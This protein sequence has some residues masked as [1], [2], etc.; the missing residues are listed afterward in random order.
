MNCNLMDSLYTTS[1]LEQQQHFMM[2][3]SQISAQLD[4]MNAATS[5]GNSS[6]LVA[7]SSNLVKPNCLNLVKYFQH[8]LQNSRPQQH[9]GLNGGGKMFPTPP[10][11]NFMQNLLTANS[12]LK[13]STN[14]SNGMMPPVGFPNNCIDPQSIRPLSKTTTQK[15]K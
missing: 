11:L 6:S 1:R 4:E 2:M 15:G 13:Q 14:M 12:I 7:S 9:I 3:A 8:I 5:N 10:A